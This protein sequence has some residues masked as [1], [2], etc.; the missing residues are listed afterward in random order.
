MVE[1]YIVV[2][3]PAVTARI[4]IRDIVY[5]ER[6]KRKLHIVTDF[7]EYSYY[8]KI[9]NIEPLL[10]GRFFSCLKGCFINLEKVVSMRDR[11]ITFENGRVL[12]LGRENFLKT[13]QYYQIYIKNLFV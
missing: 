2:L 7:E 10:D 13:V 12:Y 8:E 3:T 9:E 6:D 1:D 4:R 11:K 5:I